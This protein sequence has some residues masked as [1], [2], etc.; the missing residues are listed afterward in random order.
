[1]LE[2]CNH[3]LWT[4][5]GWGEQRL[6]E[7]GNVRTQAEAFGD[8]QTGS[9]ATTCHQWHVWQ[10]RAAFLQGLRGW[11]ANLAQIRVTQHSVIDEILDFGPIRAAR[12]SDIQRGETNIFHGPSEQTGQA[13]THFFEHH[14]VSNFGH[15]TLEGWN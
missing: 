14:R 1:M 6:G 13:M 3:G 5:E 4:L 8:V 10:A 7:R 9:D 12:T 15:D 2:V 11:N